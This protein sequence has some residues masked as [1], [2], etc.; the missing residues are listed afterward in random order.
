MI[1][2][3]KPKYI[4]SISSYYKILQQRNNLLK[5]YQNKIKEGMN[6]NSLDYDLIHVLNE[7]LANEAEVI[8][9]I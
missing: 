6:F 4:E 5:K 2:S 9:R 3:L 8:Y 7:Q 1:S